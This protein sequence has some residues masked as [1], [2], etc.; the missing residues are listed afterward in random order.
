MLPGNGGN[1]QVYKKKILEFRP[2]LQRLARYSQMIWLNQYPTLEFYGNISES[3]TQIH[4]KKIHHYNKAVRT[5][6]M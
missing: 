1:Y 6:L 3:N 2:T 4:S 5:I